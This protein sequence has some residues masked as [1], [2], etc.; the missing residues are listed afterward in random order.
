MRAGLAAIPIVGGPTNEVLS[1]ILTPALQRRRDEWHK[2]LADVVE[3]LE[4]RFSGF[5][6]RSLG[7]NEAFI[8]ATIQATRIAASTH[9]KEKREML[10]NA[11]LNIAVGK[12]PNEG[13]QQIFLNAI[14]AFTCSH[15]K[16]LDFLWRQHNILAESSRDSREPV[17][18]YG[19]AINIG[20]PE[21][22]KVAGLLEPILNDL[23]LR[24]FSDVSSPRDAFPRNPAITNLGIEFLHFIEKLQS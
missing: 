4:K 2:D 11:L 20:L 22:R 24:G 21:L 7:E 19:H 14:D 8:S 6:P 10:R 1:L 15:V 13:L 17:S 3:E 18:N 23:K 9:Q 12:G 5:D 16:V